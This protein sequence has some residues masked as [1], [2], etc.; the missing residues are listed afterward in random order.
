M[1]SS[2][3][4][5]TPIVDLTRKRQKKATTK[6]NSFYQKIKKRNPVPPYR[7]PNEISLFAFYYK[8]FLSE[9][10]TSCT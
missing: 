6:N 1:K 3:V 2:H 8:S 7:L 5:I 4:L 10:R 9:R